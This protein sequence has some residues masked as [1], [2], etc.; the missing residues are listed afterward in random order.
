MKKILIVDD[1]EKVRVLVRK[2]LS[3]G[4]YLILEAGTGEDAVRIARAE[5]PE[6]II[7]DIM[8]PGKIDGLAAVRIIKRDPG[9]KDCY[10]MMLTAKGQE[11]DRKKGLESG[12]DDYFAKPF[13]PRDLIA[14]VDEI[15]TD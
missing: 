2:T 13:R 15:L 10:V 4:D 7:M 8:M 1:H 6:V 9:T 12:A 3:F 5:C 14:K 11:S